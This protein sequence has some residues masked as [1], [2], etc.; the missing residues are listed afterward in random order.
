MSKSL[1][2]L[3]LH[4]IDNVN[5]EVTIQNYN[6][7]KEKNVDIQPIHDE[8]LKGLPDSFPVPIDSYIPRGSRRWSTETVLLNYILQNKDN[9][10]HD[11]YMFCEWDCYCNCDLNKFIIPYT[12]YDVVA[13]YIVN[14]K[15]EP[16]WMWFRD[17]S[18]LKKENLSNK[19]IGFRPSVFIL[20]KKESLIL[21]AEAYKKL[22]NLFNNLNSESRLG[23]I[24]NLLNFR[25]GE[26]K[27][28]GNSVA[29]FESVFRKESEII[30]PV[31]IKISNELYL[32][33][34]PPSNSFSGEW[35]FGSLQ[36]SGKISKVYGEITLNSNGT[37]S[38]I[39]DNFN[40]KYWNVINKKLVI[41]NG[42][43]GITTIY[44]K[45]IKNGIYVGD[46]HD[47]EILNRNRIIRKNAHF[48]LKKELL[49]KN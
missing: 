41:Y 13:P 21:L 25:I 12:N 49:R 29:W 17:L 33:E 48:L 47:G 28:L 36:S 16:G 37:I 18:F 4:N 26:Y 27:N 32:E 5:E 11:F 38:G 9:L 22:W 45:E 31:K 39:Y 34:P 44:N 23:T 19:K 35:H 8:D 3:F 24:C 20:F 15:H 10:K 6:S 42:K 46:Y 43:G 30:H 14:V 2:V 7:F 40:E 1:Q